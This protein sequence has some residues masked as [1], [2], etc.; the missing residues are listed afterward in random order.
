MRIEANRDAAE[1]DLKSA[2]FRREANQDAAKAVLESAQFR[3]E[4]NRDAAGALLESAQFRRETNR[5]AAEAVLESAQARQVADKALANST[6]SH[7]VVDKANA[8]KSAIDATSF[9]AQAERSK[10]GKTSSYIVPSRLRV[11]CSRFCGKQ[12]TGLCI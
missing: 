2:Q 9:V 1:A 5:H 8:F 6:I 10:Q 12:T 11:T 7:R 4:A 3:R